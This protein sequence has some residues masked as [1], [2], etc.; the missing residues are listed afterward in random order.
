MLVVVLLTLRVSRV[1]EWR[2]ECDAEWNR[3]DSSRV[4]QGFIS[5]SFRSN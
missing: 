4:N 2:M 3:V 1:M 5:L